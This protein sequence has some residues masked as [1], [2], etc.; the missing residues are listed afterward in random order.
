MPFSLQVQF[1]WKCWL[2]FIHPIPH[3]M[4]TKQWVPRQ[5]VTLTVAMDTK[6]YKIMCISRLNISETQN[7]K[8]LQENCILVALA[9]VKNCWIFI[10]CL[11][12]HRAR[13]ARRLD[14]TVELVIIIPPANKS[15]WGYVPCLY[16]ILLMDESR[17]S[18]LKN[19]KGDN[20]RKIFSSSEWGY[21]FWFDSHS[22]F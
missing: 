20:S 13:V 9:Y 17:W 6:V 21:S 4:E 2:N 12:L 18:C 10:L 3:V 1:H 14:S 15:L 16:N 22:Q 7:Y 8:L 11:L 5:C 19:I